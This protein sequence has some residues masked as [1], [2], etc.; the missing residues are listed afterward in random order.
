MCG[1]WII[2]K[3][4]QKSADLH[5]SIFDISV[6][7]GGRADT[8]NQAGSPPIRFRYWFSEGRQIVFGRIFVVT[9]FFEVFFS[10]L[11]YFYF[12]S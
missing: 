12:N 3:S 7:V 1:I 9:L 5:P 8:L 10:S 11:V 2:K 4:N 6:C